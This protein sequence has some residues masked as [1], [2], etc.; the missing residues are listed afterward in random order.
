M[1]GN[2]LNSGEEATSR[3]TKLICV[4]ICVAL[5]L[6]LRGEMMI[7]RDKSNKGYNKQRQWM[8]ACERER[9]GP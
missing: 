2:D 3:K 4:G 8:D 9:D 5:S 1:I 6:L 7:D